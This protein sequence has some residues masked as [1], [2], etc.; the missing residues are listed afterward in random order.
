LSN[1]KD[2]NRCAS[3]T[4]NHARAGPDLKMRGPSKS[5]GK[6]DSSRIKRRNRARQEQFSIPPPALAEQPA[7]AGPTLNRQKKEE[8]NKLNKKQ[9]EDGGPRSIQ[10]A[11]KLQF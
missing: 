4:D 3:S 5:T 2:E 7:C 9:E 1:F 10:L 11:L 6:I 8:E